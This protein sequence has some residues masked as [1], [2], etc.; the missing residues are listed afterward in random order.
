MN[1]HSSLIFQTQIWNGFKELNLWLSFNLA[2]KNIIDG[3]LPFISLTVRPWLVSDSGFQQKLG[4]RREWVICQNASFESSFI[5]NSDVYQDGLNLS[6]SCEGQTSVRH[7]KYRI[8]I[9]TI[10][11]ILVTKWRPRLDCCEK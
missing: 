11:K 10:T 2:M 8:F 7:F 6:Q 5:R 1:F 9:S 4:H 3:N